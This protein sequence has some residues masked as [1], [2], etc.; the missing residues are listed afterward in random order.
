M[1][2][3]FRKASYFVRPMPQYV[4]IAGFLGA[5]VATVTTGQHATIAKI[6]WVEESCRPV[7]L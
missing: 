3:R 1:K 2:Q 5:I 7:G 4:A 6:Y